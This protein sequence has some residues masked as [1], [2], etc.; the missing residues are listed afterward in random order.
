[1]KAKIIDVYFDSQGISILRRIDRQQFLYKKN[2]TCHFKIVIKFNFFLLSVFKMIGREQSRL[3][4][5]TPSFGFS[6]VRKIMQTIFN[7]SE[8]T[9]YALIQI[10]KRF[11]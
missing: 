8:L 10:F 9:R 2:N 1:M 4:H 11:Y 7:L 3:Q 5:D 6:K